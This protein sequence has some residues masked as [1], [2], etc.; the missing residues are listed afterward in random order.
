MWNIRGKTYN[1]KPF[2]HKHPGG[3]TI[4]ESCMGNDD[5][6]ATFESYHALCDMEKIEPIMKKYEVSS[7]Q[8]TKML[9][10]TNGFYK[11]IQKRVIKKL[12]EELLRFRKNLVLINF[13][14]LLKMKDSILIQD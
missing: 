12:K 1:L 3:K 2:L 10:K 13:K 7:C 4:L 14:K 8:P 11:T 5:L 9:F 6:T